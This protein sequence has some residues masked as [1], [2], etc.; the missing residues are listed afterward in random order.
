MINPSSV[1][2]IRYLCIKF[3]NDIGFAPPECKSLLEACFAVIRSSI[4]TC[5]KRC[6]DDLIR[7]KLRNNI[8]GMAMLLVGP[9]WVLRHVKKVV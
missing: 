9:K 7:L 2:D 3:R 8:V 6:K 4:V 1:H 5:H